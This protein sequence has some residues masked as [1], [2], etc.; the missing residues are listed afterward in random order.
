MAK[1]HKA[2]LMKKLL[3]GYTLFLSTTILFCQTNYIKYHQEARLIESHILDSSYSEAIQEYKKLFSKY[4]FV[5]AEDCYRATQTATISNDSIN[6]F[7]FLERSVKQGVTKERILSDS[8]L[9]ELK[10]FKYWSKFENKY[11]S[12]RNDYISG[13]NWELR[14]KINNL[15]DLD[16]KYRDK[17]EL[18]P[19]NFIWRPLIWLKW[20]KITEKIVENELIPLIKKYGFPNE[21]LIG[22]DE[23]KYHHKQKYDYLS[24]N[25]AF[26]I[27]I[28]YFS[29][30][31]TANFNKLFYDAIKTGNISPKQYASLI[32]FQAE[33]GKDKYYHGL[34]Y[35][36]WHKSNDETEYN[37]INKNR[38]KIGLEPL[39]IQS[40]KYKRGLDACKQRKNG[41][42]K[43]IRF[44]IFCG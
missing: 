19:W 7:L 11:D 43:Q 44:W 24:S 17:H 23:A 37:Q 8:I 12:L 35:N 2:T 13:I 9:I 26:I 18:H 4:N 28:H 21:K 29:I 38:I 42:Y 16:Q 27:L 6:S 34:H 10:K 3:L 15:H 40:L 30:P 25:Y 32:D 22:L 41:N 20:K 14:K 36:E 39:E 33:Y 1:I 31:R 5:F